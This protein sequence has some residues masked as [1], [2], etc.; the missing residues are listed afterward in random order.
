MTQLA[1]RPVTEPVSLTPLEQRVA[2][3]EQ[4]PAAA[5][6][7]GPVEQQIATL[8]AEI[9]AMPAGAPSPDLGPLENRVSAMERQV[10][11]VL[12]LKSQLDTIS[13]QLAGQQ[14]EFGSRLTQLAT[15]Q[16]GLAV[17]VH[18]LNDALGAAQ[19]SVSKQLQ[20]VQQQ[21]STAVAAAEKSARLARIEA[22]RAALEAGRPVGS[23]DGAPPAL[24]RFAATSPP[25]E[26]ALR[27][28]FPAAAKAAL[29]AA[30]PDTAGKPFGERLWQRAQQLITV[31]E[32]D[33]V[34][35]GDPAS[36]VL[37]HTQQE[38]DAGDLSGAVASV[39]TLSGPTAQAMASWLDQANALLAARAALDTMAAHA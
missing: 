6:D 23:I 37:A 28:A 30:Q 9:T 13:R 36:G 26:A 29:D 27:L 8:K 17:Q 14:A 38:L 4:R 24:A 15:D 11:A 1:Q 2:A 16:R 31:R 34:I 32:G 39:S 21:A 18:D 12:A 19:V 5:P 20:T 22:A 33:R 10:Q 7:L 35:V 25:T 3:L